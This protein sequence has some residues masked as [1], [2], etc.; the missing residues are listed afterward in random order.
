[1]DYSQMGARLKYYRLQLKKT[2]QELA[3]QCDITKSFLSK[4]ENGKV[5][6]S[7][8]TLSKLA[9]GL[10]LTVSDILSQTP[11]KREWQHD[12]AEAVAA[13]LCS[14]ANGYRLFPFADHLAYKKIQPFYYEVKKDEIR[15]HKDAHKGEEFYYVIDGE[16][17]LIL[18]GEE[19]RLKKGDGFYFD[20]AY[21]HQ[22]IPI[23]DEVKILDI[24]VCEPT[25]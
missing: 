21:D 9:A 19:H 5:M 13:G 16:L 8:G 10:N 6:P 23:T 24:I 22:T 1:M 14:I 4:I 11:E 15:P 2:Q 17:L 12:S 20:S 25:P 18:K 7:L 3:D